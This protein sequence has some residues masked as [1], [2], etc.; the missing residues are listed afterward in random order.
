[1]AEKIFMLALSPTMES[2]LISKWLKKEGDTITSGDVL[3]EVETDKATM[4]YETSEEGTL[5]KI[6]LQDGSKAAI[7]D[8]IAVIGKDREDISEI[9]DEYKASSRDTSEDKISKNEVNPVGDE[10]D[11]NGITDTK[12]RAAENENAVP[13]NTVMA[14]VSKNTEQDRKGSTDVDTRTEQDR[15]GNTVDDTS[16]KQQNRM[17]NNHSKASDRSSPL[18]RKIAENNGID[19]TRVQGTGPQGR[20]VKRDIDKAILKATANSEM[21]VSDSA[22]PG[23]TLT[24]MN[25][26]DNIQRAPAY[27]T[28]N[29]IL[30]V[31]TKRKIIAKRLSDSMFTAPHYY[32]KVSIAMDELLEARSKLASNGEKLSLN[33]YIMKLTAIAL[34]RHPLVNSGWNGETITR[35]GSADIA[36]AVAQTD[37]LITPIVRNCENL[38]IRE[39]DAQLKQLIPKAQNGGLKPEE[40]TGATFTISN[41]GSYGMEEFTAI[42]NP[43]GSAILAVGQTIKTP[44]VDENDAIAIKSMMK[45]TLSCD[46]RVI[47][48]AV[49][50]AFLDDLRKMIEDPYRA[51]L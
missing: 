12:T 21:T 44:V 23:S 6:L 17:D 8:L 38:G 34:K 50:A 29:Q 16:V 10:H 51:L 25:K 18:S 5:L 45:V 28:E 36:L 46:H 47:D 30:P 4:D 3:C 40:Y 9:L 7:G 24:P 26:S 33:A 13:H 1:M 19:W 2:G 20:V 27:I 48:G 39:I 31:S 43:P 15:N 32:L 41:L 37:G 22:G 49:G 42:I 11:K 14:T 35:F